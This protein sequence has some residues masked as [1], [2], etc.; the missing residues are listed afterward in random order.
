MEI[1]L[2]SPRFFH[3][4]RG[5]VPEKFTKSPDWKGESVRVEGVQRSEFMIYVI[6][7]G[8]MKSVKIKI[9]IP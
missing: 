8:I 1:K 7:S 2:C 5:Y 3:I 9:K 6:I 4:C